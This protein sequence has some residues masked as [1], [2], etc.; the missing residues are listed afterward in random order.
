MN[1]W[2]GAMNHWQRLWA[3]LS[4]LWATPL[5]SASLWMGIWAVRE[6]DRL[7]SVLLAMLALLVPSLLYLLTLIALWIINT[8][9]IEMVVSAN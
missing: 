3:L 8:G 2:Q 4:I 7:Y 1:H 9:R 5:M 6:H